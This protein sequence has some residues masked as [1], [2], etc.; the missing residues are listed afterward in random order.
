MSRHHPPEDA[1]MA[2]AAGS[3]PE[4]HSLVIATNLPM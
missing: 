3:L 4:P 2:Y 1:L